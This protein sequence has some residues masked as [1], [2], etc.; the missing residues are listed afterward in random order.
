MV[1]FLYSQEYFSTCKNIPLLASD[2][3]CTCHRT[4]AP[5]LARE[6]V[7][8]VAA[9][10][11]A[12]RVPIQGGLAEGRAP[13]SVGPPCVHGGSNVA[14]VDAE[15]IAVGAGIAC[16]EDKGISEERWG[17]EEGGEKYKEWKDGSEY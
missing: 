9:V 12:G 6:E 4:L 2:Y 15:T 1:M 17:G 10:P 7:I 16:R 13:V 14:S 11:A 8:R 5:L 3:S